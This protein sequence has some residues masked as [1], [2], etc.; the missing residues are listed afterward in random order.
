MRTF[1]RIAA[2]VTSLGIASAL[3]VGVP[4]QASDSAELS[5]AAAPQVAAV[6]P[7]TQAVSTLRSCTPAPDQPAQVRS[8]MYLYKDGPKFAGEAMVTDIDGGRDYSVLAVDLRIQAYLGGE[9][10][11]ISNTWK[12]DADGWFDKRDIAAHTNWGTCYGAGQTLP[13]RA[14]STIRYKLKSGG[15]TTTVT[16]TSPSARFWCP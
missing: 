12:A 10:R 5:S 1:V 2:A 4:A 14:V 7:T 15:A 8:C 13:M 6:S 3:A 16:R 11:L 9:W